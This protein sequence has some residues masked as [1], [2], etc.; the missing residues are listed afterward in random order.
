[1]KDNF[2]DQI[3]ISEKLDSAIESGIQ[4]AV[5]K[6]RKRR[7][8]IISL[9][10]VAFVFSNLIF[11][12][13]TTFANVK[14]FFI[15]IASYFNTSE[16]I[17]EYTAS[18]G[19]SV[20]NNGY[21]VTLNEALMNENELVVS[22]TIKSDKG[23]ISS[24]IDFYPTILVNGKQ[25]SYDS[26][27]MLDYED[28]TTI[29]SIGTYRFKEELVGDLKI[30]IQYESV[31]VSE[32]SEAR[33]VEGSWNFA[34]DINSEAL[35]KDSTVIEL[36]KVITL[37]SGITIDFTEYKGNAF[38]TTIKTSVT[39]D[40]SSLD[41]KLIGTDNLGN[42]CEFIISRLYLDENF[43]GS[44]TFM[45]DTENSELN[46]DATELKLYTY[47]REFDS[48]ED[49]NRDGDEIVINLK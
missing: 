32:N 42:S 25:L 7:Q 44:V 22:S 39:G 31:R 2:F 4:V 36:D 35:K 38:N 33:G 41:V 18:I 28:D 14:D 48:N 21:T 29:N 24:E 12:N 40:I 37:N 43:N 30:E 17:N 20:S 27:E 11:L 34:F 23:P 47:T 15:S 19:S 3:D 16:S 26:D 6:K 46:S 9:S 10:V 5:L 1:M 45:L 13:T 8:R 49:F